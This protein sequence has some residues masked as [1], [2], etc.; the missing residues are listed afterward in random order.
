MRIV[1]NRTLCDG[2]GNCAAAAPELLLL[3]G[4][5]KV[6]VLMDSFG[7]DMQAKAE[8][9]IRSCPKSALKLEK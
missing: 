6:I 1:V 9:A 3:G 8:A 4:N 2:N 7:E 5:G